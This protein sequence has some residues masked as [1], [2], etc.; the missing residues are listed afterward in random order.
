MKAELGAEGTQD[1][2]D[3][4]EKLFE[5]VA[6]MEK[7][8]ADTRKIAAD[9]EERLAK[10]EEEL[11]TQT[12]DYTAKIQEVHIILGD[13]QKANVE[14]R[15]MVNASYAGDADAPKAL[16]TGSCKLDRED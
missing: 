9:A 15:N 2:K 6:H 11:V 1:N 13:I 14:T 10:I 7:T 12:A 4:L 16:Q 5:R 8:A 3:L